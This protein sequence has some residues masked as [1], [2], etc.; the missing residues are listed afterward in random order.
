MKWFYEKNTDFLQHSVNKKFEEILDMTNAEFQ[1]W[2]IELRKVVVD[3]WD[4][5]NQPPRVGYTEAEM[6]EQF[7]DMIGYPIHEFLA[8][9]QLT[10]EKNVRTHVRRLRSS[11]TVALR[12]KKSPKSVF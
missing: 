4:N 1:Q 2:C 12:G 10:G 8:E 7:N 3:L 9:D 6:A 11:V 5:K